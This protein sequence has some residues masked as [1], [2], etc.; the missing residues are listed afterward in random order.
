MSEKPSTT[1][2]DDQA[3]SRRARDQEIQELQEAIAGQLTRMIAELVLVRPPSGA[4]PE[5][6][7]V[8]VTARRA[9]AA[10]REHERAA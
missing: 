3:P 2:V 7:R 6:Q 1:L 4:P 5:V 10:A 8:V 9:L